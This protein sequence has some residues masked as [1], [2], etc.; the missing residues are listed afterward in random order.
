MPDAT[1]R[2]DSPTNLYAES[3]SGCNRGHWDD[4]HF[5]LAVGRAMAMEELKPS[6]EPFYELRKYHGVAPEAHL[7]IGDRDD[8]D[9]EGARLSGCRYLDVRALR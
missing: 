6:P 7:H 9:G 5:A 2:M 8:T 4:G 1:K 3:I